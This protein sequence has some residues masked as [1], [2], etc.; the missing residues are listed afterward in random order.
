MKLR[1][2]MHNL[3]VENAD[4]RRMDV[5]QIIDDTDPAYLQKTL[6]TR[7]PGGSLQAGSQFLTPMTVEDLKS[8]EWIPLSHPAVKSPAIAFTAQIPGK[9]GIT[10]IDNLDD[11][12]PVKFQ[13]SHGGTGGKSGRSAEVVS[14]FSDALLRVDNT[15]LIA[16]PSGDKTVVWTFHPGDPSPPFNEITIDDVRELY[17]DMLATAREARELGFNFVKKVDSLGINEGRIT[18]FFKGL[19]GI[20]TYDKEKMGFN[21]PKN[22]WFLKHINELNPAK[23]GSLMRSVSSAVGQAPYIMHDSVQSEVSRL[24]DYIRA[25]LKQRGYDNEY[26]MRV[27]NG[28]IYHAY[29]GGSE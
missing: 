4:L 24:R 14:T 2:L 17:P 1:S 8:A 19:A 9:L 23:L 28:L 10:E 6:D 12:A 27:S 22:E 13:L 25:T 18:D 3:F 16:G 15:T 21:V 7:N 11:D 26:A 29:K 5:A 20:P